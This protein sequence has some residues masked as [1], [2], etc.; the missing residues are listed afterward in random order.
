EDCGVAVEVGNGEEAG[1][2]DGEERFLGVEVLD[3]DGEDVAGRW[4]LVAEALQI[5]LAERTLPGESLAADHPRAVRP[6]H[7]DRAPGEG[8]RKRIGILEGHG[9]GSSSLAASGGAAQAVA[10]AV[11]SEAGSG[12]RRV[13]G[14]S[15]AGREWRQLAGEA[16]P[17]SAVQR[18]LRRAP[19]AGRD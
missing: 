1:R 10:V 16:P 18:R 5:G 3:G 2:R 14:P 11:G 8:P 9:H 15:V 17:G 4:W 13:D 7:A 12:Y 6:F 19:A